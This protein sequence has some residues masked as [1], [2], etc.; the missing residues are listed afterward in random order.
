MPPK[1]KTA[2]KAKT[3]ARKSTAKTPA[4]KSPKRVPVPSQ[5]VI[6]EPAP[7]KPAVPAP[8]T[9]QIAAK[10]YEIWV[11]KG[12]PIGQDDLNWIEAEQALSR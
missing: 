9:E 4:A 7:Q 12:R 1:A 11:A 2:P 3:Q 5:P 8:T 6:V 10:A